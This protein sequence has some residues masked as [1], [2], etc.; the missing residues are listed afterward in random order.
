[1]EG[2]LAP[3]V[4]VVLVVVHEYSV[5]APREKTTSWANFS[6][7]VW[8]PVGPHTRSLDPCGLRT[9]R[10]VVDLPS[11]SASLLKDTGGTSEAV[12]LN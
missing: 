6:E 11:G 10:L 7:K 5:P 8:G 9:A 3:E 2:T 1:M 12:V 4:V